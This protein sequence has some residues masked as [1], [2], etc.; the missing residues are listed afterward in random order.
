MKLLLLLLSMNLYAVYDLWDSEK[1]E[2]Y[3]ID[4]LDLKET[5]AGSTQTTLMSKVFVLYDNAHEGVLSQCIEKAENA[6]K[7]WKSISSAHLITTE[8]C[9]DDKS[10]DASSQLTFAAE[11]N[12]LYVTYTVFGRD[13]ILLGRA[14]MCGVKPFAQYIPESHRARY[15]LQKRECAKCPVL[16]DFNK[17]EECVISGLRLSRMLEGV[18]CDSDSDL[19]EEVLVQYNKL[20]NGEFFK[21]IQT[22]QDDVKS[23]VRSYVAHQHKKLVSEISSQLM[24]NADEEGNVVAQCSMTVEK[25]RLSSF[26]QVEQ[27]CE[28]MHFSKYIARLHRSPCGFKPEIKIK[29]AWDLPTFDQVETLFEDIAQYIELLHR[30]LRLAIKRRSAWTVST[31]DPVKIFCKDIAQY[32]KRVYS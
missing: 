2:Q 8:M 32:I 4:T 20:S 24:F 22:A 19:L 11:A 3:W 16:W 30:D 25:K 29:S 26:V 5:L 31:F 14:H 10:D 9:I 6:A 17:S 1:S 15:V 13:T 18:S 21:R 28:F 7:E 27:C 23:M 12:K